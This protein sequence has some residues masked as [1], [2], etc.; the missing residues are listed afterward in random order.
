MIKY[1]T[2][3][4]NRQ[5]DSIG[6]ILDS[7]TM[8]IYSGTQP[9]NPE[10][11]A[12]GD[13]LATI[14]LPADALADSVDGVSLINGTWIGLVILGGTAGWFRITCVGYDATMII[15]GTVGETAD[16]PD[17]VLDEKTLVLGGNVVVNTFS[18]TTPQ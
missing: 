9:T 12:V 8:D 4:R 15:D 13:L 2:P 18:L 10:D 1:S 5:S 11:E 14:E 7:A 16:N 6:V 17:A 3:I